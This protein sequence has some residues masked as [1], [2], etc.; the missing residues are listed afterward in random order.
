M[1]TR[2]WLIASIAVAVAGFASVAA[3]APPQCPT[4]LVRSPQERPGYSMGVAR[5]STTQAIDIEFNV[6]LLHLDGQEHLLQLRLLLPS[7]DLYQTIDVPI[8]G[9]AGPPLGEPSAARLKGYPHAVPKARPEWFQVGVVP[10]QLLRV[11]FP[12]AGTAIMHNALHGRWTVE[13]YL[14]GSDSPCGQ[15]S[16]FV[17]GR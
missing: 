4:I 7:G 8:A 6:L 16:K 10:F 17:V 9:T 13:A 15:G 11:P 5:V 12:V 14:D 3:A 2:P 1:S